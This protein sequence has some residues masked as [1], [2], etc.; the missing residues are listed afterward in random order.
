MEKIIGNLSAKPIYTYLYGLAFLFFKTSAYI[1]NFEY[2]TA[3]VYIISFFILTYFIDRLVFSMIGSGYSALF[4]LVIW[5]SIFHV[6]GIAQKIGYPY[7]YIPLKFYLIFYFTVITLL[8][9]LGLFL[10]KKDYPIIISKALNVFLS[11][12]IIIFSADG[13][14]SWFNTRQE[15]ISHEHQIES[16]PNHDNKE[17][18]WIL[19]D[20]YGSSKSL[21]KLMGFQNPMDSLLK[22]RGFEVFEHAKSRSSTTL[23]SVYSIFNLDDSVKPSSYY[24]G[25][26]L[27]RNSKL[28]P[29]L[30][31]E[32]YRFVNLGFLISLD[33]P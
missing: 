12:T 13:I 29:S 3:L 22:Q 7:A 10:I 27:L 4:A 6:V 16:R 25:I 18:V 24:E 5:M 32:G 30:E 33:I 21:E 15:N 28:V 9:F 14:K 23:F 19:M 8:I 20:E 17:I 31:I 26:N 2:K 1:G 11:I